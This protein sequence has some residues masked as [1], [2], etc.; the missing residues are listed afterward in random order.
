MGGYAQ[1]MTVPDYEANLA[2]QLSMNRETWRT[3]Q[4][5]G[6]SET[7]PIRIDFTYYAPNRKAAD[8]LQTLIKQQTD[9]DVAVQQEGR[10]LRRTWRVE[11]STQPQA[12]SLSILDQW[13]QWMVVAG[14]ECSC[15]FD[16]WGAQV[17]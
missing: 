10:L 17:E 15:V 4:E 12:V 9:Y 14:K 6:V 2:R 3:L 16:G 8:A 1:A 7:A 13:V 5:H 11:G